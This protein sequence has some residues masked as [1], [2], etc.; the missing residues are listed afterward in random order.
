MLIFSSY[1]ACKNFCHFYDFL[2]DFL[3]VGYLETDT[4]NEYQNKQLTADF[5]WWVEE[6]G[7]LIP[8]K[9]GDSSA[10]LPWAAAAAVSGCVIIVLIARR[11]RE[12]EENA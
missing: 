2:L 5:K 6:T 12:E 3:F 10:V 9:T 11:R 1:F 7:N 4:G 8:P